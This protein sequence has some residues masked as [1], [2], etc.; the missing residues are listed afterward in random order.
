MNAQ[1]TP[2][3]WAHIETLPDRA[4]DYAGETF[5]KAEANG[6]TIATL[7]NYSPTER[8]ANARLIAA[9]PDLLEAL[10][11]ARR[12]LRPS[13]HDT[14]FVDAAIASAMIAKHKESA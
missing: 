8:R 11:Y 1:H 5:I 13:E 10:R 7:S 2:G 9:A 12:F 14:A 6:V 4:I 3:P